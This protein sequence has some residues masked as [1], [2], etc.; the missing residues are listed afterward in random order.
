[1]FPIS[2]GEFGDCFKIT[3]FSKKRFNY[4]PCLKTNQFDV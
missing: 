1:M 3:T 4:K 2:Y